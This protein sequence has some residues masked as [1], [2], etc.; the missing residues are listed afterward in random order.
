MVLACC[1]WRAHRGVAL[2]YAF[3]GWWPSLERLR[4]LQRGTDTSQLM[5]CGSSAPAWR[6]CKCAGRR[7]SRMVRGGANLRAYRG[8]A[9]HYAFVGRW[10]SVERLK[11]LQHDANAPQLM[12]R[13]R[14]NARTSLF[15]VK[16]TDSK[17]KRRNGPFTSATW[18]LRLVSLVTFNMAPGSGLPRSMR[19]CYGPGHWDLQPP[20]WERRPP[21]PAYRWDEQ[22]PGRSCAHSAACASLPLLEVAR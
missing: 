5:T 21:A 15:T 14:R 8:V 4:G 11:A 10:L 1:N 7:C 18:S 16:F 3:V 13:R 20:S 2:Q 22:V 9:R 6:W 12:T 17:R 19:I